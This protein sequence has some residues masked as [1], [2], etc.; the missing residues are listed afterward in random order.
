[1]T[2]TYFCPA[3]ISFG[4]VIYFTLEIGRPLRLSGGSEIARF[5]V[6]ETIAAHSLREW[7]VCEGDATSRETAQINGDSALF[8]LLAS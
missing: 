1:M 7:Q 3:G 2:N 4:D 8:L 5:V 6:S